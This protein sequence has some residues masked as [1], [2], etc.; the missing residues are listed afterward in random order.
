MIPPLP[1]LFSGSQGGDEDEDESD[2]WQDGEGD[3]CPLCGHEYQQDEFWIACD[4]CDRWFCG[5]CTKVGARVA[6]DLGREK[7]RRA[8]SAGSPLLSSD[9]G[10]CALLSPTWVQLHC[11]FAYTPQTALAPYT[12][13]KSTH[14]N[15]R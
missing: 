12:L 10:P 13:A 8:A 11:W 5:R 2:E 15:D 1:P 3:P 4:K 14:M 9:C 7:Q 6:V